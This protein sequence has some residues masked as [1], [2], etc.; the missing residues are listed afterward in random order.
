MLGVIEA[1]KFAM[2]A[3]ATMRSASRRALILSDYDR[4]LDR[5][6]E[7]INFSHD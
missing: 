3:A 1:E 6:L 7:G 4:T 5:I 2:P